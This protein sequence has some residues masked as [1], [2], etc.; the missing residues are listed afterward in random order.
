M[1]SLNNS[2]ESPVAV[3]TGTNRATG[4][5][6]AQELYELGWTVVSMNR[7]LSGEDWLH[8]YGC[9]LADLDAV[10]R[11]AARIVTGY[12]FVHAFVAAAAVRNLSAVEQL[13][14][15][16]LEKTVKV[17]LISVVVTV[18]ELLPALRRSR[19]SIIMI[20]SHSGSRFF[21]GGAAYSTSKAA[22][23][24]LAETLLLEE[25]P[26]G[27]RTTLVSPG[28]ISN[29]AGDNSPYK[30]TTHSV[31]SCVRS[32]LTEIP[33]DTVVG[34]VEIR[35]ARLPEPGISGLDRLQFV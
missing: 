2:A 24:A 26:N 25:R 22:L 31:A 15:E 20:G 6:V 30:M 18:R 1:V 5:A 13:P 4:R 27:V 8:E 23:K 28:A 10:A 21:E 35:P 19:G 33:R 34:E 29:F 3:V 11:T 16:T 17:N 12:R 14:S 7:T 32:L 9:D